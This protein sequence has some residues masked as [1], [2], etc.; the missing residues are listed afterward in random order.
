MIK[1]QTLFTLV[2]SGGFK[3]KQQGDFITRGVPPTVLLQLSE[4]RPAVAIYWKLVQ[5]IDPEPGPDEG[6]DHIPQAVGPF[7][8]G[9]DRR[10]IFI[11]IICL[12]LPFDGLWL[13]KVGFS[14]FKISCFFGVVK[15]MEEGMTIRDIKKAS[16]LQEMGDDLSSL[17]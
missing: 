3:G 2:W 7:I 6:V 9:M 4:G 10:G 8:R 5:E 12:R 1:R 14:D 17:L 11:C 13:I 15:N 16:R